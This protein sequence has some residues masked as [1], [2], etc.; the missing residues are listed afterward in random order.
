MRRPSYE[1]PQRGNPHQLTINQHIL[2]RLVIQRFCGPDGLVYVKRVGREGFINVQP[3]NPLFC[4]KRVW[5]QR[6]ETTLSEEIEASFQI[7]SNSILENSLSTLDPEMH[8]MVTE[9]YLLWRYRALYARKPLGDVRANI[10]RMERNLSIDSQERLEKNGVLFLRPDG[11]LPGRISTGVALQMDIDRD[12]Q[13]G[14][15]KMHWGIVKAPPD[16]QFVVP[17]AFINQPIM[18]IS[19]STC[20]VSGWPDSVLS[21]P[22]VGLFNREAVLSADEYWF[23]KNPE[24][25]P[26]RRLVFPFA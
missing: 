16:F 8:L 10:V 22:E 26:I 20:L 6:A 18:P 3:E 2:P 1:E 25:C 19:P 13:A 4:A 23:A 24:R 15:D 21:M 9:M 7:V 17:N 12:L 14:A 5:D 11:T